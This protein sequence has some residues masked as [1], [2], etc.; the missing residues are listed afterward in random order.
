[1]KSRINTKYRDLCET[2]P[3]SLFRPL[4]KTNTKIKMN[5]VNVTKD[6]SMETSQ[7]K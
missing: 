2:Y 3:A 4:Q 7:R 6:G 5:K 1:M